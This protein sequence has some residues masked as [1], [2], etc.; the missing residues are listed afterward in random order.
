MDF[1]LVLRRLILWGGLTIR[2]ERIGHPPASQVGRSS[3]VAIWRRSIKDIFKAIISLLRCVVML[4]RNIL[5]ERLDV[6]WLHGLRFASWIR[7]C[8]G[9]LGG[10]ILKG[11]I[12]VFHHGG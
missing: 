10:G 12:G 5:P 8:F 4:T 2:Q 6:R 11:R 1:S 9:F 7:S 3:W